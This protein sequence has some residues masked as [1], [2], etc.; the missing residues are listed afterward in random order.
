[1]K[2]GPVAD[3]T[4]NMRPR[5]DFIGQFVK[6][7]ELQ[8]DSNGLVFKLTDLGE[9]PGGHK[10][11]SGLD[12]STT[13][14]EAL[15]GTTGQTIPSLSKFPS[16]SPTDTNCHGVCVKREGSDEGFGLQTQDDS[17]RQNSMTALVAPLAAHVHNS[18][19]KDRYSL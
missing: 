14:G 17:L 4:S 10:G 8:V 9:E 13:L 7:H 18:N 12:S 16:R 5:E 15:W 2:D 1:M 3:S 6:E 11:F 19:R